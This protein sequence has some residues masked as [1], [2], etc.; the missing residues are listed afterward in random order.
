MCSLT[1]IHDR[2]KDRPVV[3]TEPGERMLAAVALVVCDAGLGPEVL[4]IERTEHEDDP[5]SGHLGFPGGRVEATDR[6]P[7]GAAERETREEIGVDLSG[8]KYL[9]RLDDLLGAHFPVVISCFVF[10]TRR[11]PALTLNAAE[12]AH[13]FWF[14]LEDLFDP[15]LRREKTVSFRGEEVT[16]PTIQLLE[17]GR[18]CLWG[19]TYRLVSQFLEA[20]GHPL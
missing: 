3:L 20:M 2:L 11:R 14:P 15:R 8:A 18:P 7:R 10:G 16:Y 6:G 12:V 19:I 4:F 9:G 13:A 5:W 17:A 1:E